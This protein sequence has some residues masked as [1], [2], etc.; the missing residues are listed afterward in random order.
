MKQLPVFI[1]VLAMAVM[2]V[3]TGCGHEPRY[4]SRLVHADSLMQ[5][6]PDSALAI[7]EGVCRDSLADVCERAYRDLLL[8]QARYRCYVSATSDSDINRALAYYRAHPKEREKLT[9]AYIYK[10]AVM[11]ELG[12]PD[13]AMLHY[14]HAEATAAPDDYFNLGYVKMRM[15]TLYRDYY[16]IDGKEIEKFKQALEYFNRTNSKPQQLN[17]LIN[18]GSIYRL[19]LPQKADSVLLDAMSLAMQIGDTSNYV[20]AATSRAQLDYYQKHFEQAHKVIQ[21]L[22]KLNV[23]Q[24]PSFFY[25]TA[26]SVYACL[27]KTDSAEDFFNQGMTAYPITTIIDSMTYMESAGMIALARGDKRTHAMM[28]ARCRQMSDSLRALEGSIKIIH[29]ES[30]FDQSEMSEYQQKTYSLKKILII[31]IAFFILAISYLSISQWQKKRRMAKLILDLKQEYQTQLSNLKELE[32]LIELQNIQNS[33]IKEFI[34]AQMMLIREVVEEC[35]HNPKTMLSR[36]IKNLVSY[37]KGEPDKWASLFRFIDIEHG[38]IMK[39][40]SD[41]YPQ[42]NDKELLLIA[43]TTLDFSCAQIAIFFGFDRASSVGTARKRL[44]NK[45]NIG[46]PLS[47]YIDKFK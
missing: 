19:K 20:L 36:N 43:L 13:S 10:G 24:Y 3:V 46:M 39:H 17:C 31:L 7:V 4:D 23:K 33:S 44:A 25:P 34:A 27:G 14:K 2:A 32:H 5:S 47:E 18:L 41:K 40:T 11:E 37:H 15:G 45:M 8:T 12:Y 26:A 1:L 21:S 28:D 6:E 16:S 38:N 29:A 30:S 42:L 35:Y 9:R 22:T